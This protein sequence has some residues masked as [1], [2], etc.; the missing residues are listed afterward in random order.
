MKFNL[1]QKV[2]V[3]G[4]GIGIIW[5]YNKRYKE[6]TVIIEGKRIYGIKENEIV[7]A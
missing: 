2:R 7:G 1:D 6:Y 4:Y 5:D 3:I